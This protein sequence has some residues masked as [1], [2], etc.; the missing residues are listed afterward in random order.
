VF[1]DCVRVKLTSQIPPM[2]PPTRLVPVTEAVLEELEISSTA[3]NPLE[4]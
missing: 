4:S 2:R 3:K 1:L